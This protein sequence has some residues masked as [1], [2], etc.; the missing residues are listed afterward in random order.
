MD[1]GRVLILG[2]DSDKIL[3][4]LIVGIALVLLLLVLSAENVPK[5]TTFTDRTKL[6]YAFNSGCDQ[7]N[8]IYN[9]SAEKIIFVKTTLKIDNEPI[10]LLAACQDHFQNVAITP[11]E[12]VKAC[13]QCSNITQSSEK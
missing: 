3:K 4:T 10:S 11:E 5:N 9:C 13:P 7:L 1:S 2:V 12:C 8:S 6:Q